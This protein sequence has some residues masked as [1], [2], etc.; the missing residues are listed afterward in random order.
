MELK[1]STD[2]IFFF[3]FKSIIKYKKNENDS[4][5]FC[6][7]KLY[8]LNDKYTTH[9]K[10]LTSIYKFIKLSDLIESIKD[11]YPDL[12]ERLKAKYIQ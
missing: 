3:K 11:I 5:D 4:S 1:N 9:I 8:L 6:F 7:E 2:S 10:Y 12:Y